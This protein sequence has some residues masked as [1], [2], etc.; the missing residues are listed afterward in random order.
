LAWNR[1]KI[2][3]GRTG[4]G[5]VSQFLSCIAGVGEMWNNKQFIEA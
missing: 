2:R 5:V 1:L 3:A 4:L